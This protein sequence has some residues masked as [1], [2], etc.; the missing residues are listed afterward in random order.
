[1]THWKST[2]IDNYSLKTDLRGAANTLCVYPKV[3]GETRISGI[4]SGI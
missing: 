4:F 1:M 3:S 2:G